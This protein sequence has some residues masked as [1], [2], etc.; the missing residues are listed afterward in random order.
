MRIAFLTNH[1]KKHKSIFIN[2]KFIETGQIS[3]CQ[4][5]RRGQ[6]K[7]VKVVK[8]HKLLVLK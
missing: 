3:D 4:R 7:W 5:Q 6:T 1:F 8:R 2:N